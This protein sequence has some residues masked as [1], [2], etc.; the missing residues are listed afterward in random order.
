[1]TPE[2]VTRLTCVIACPFN[3]RLMK[4][5]LES[6]NLQMIC[7]PSGSNMMI[8]VTDTELGGISP[9]RQLLRST[10]I[11]LLMMVGLPCCTWS[12]ISKKH[13]GDGSSWLASWLRQNQISEHERTSLDM[14]CLIT[15]LHLSGTY[16]HLISRVWLQWKLLP[17]GLLILL[18][19][20]LVREAHHV[21]PGF[22][23]TK[24]ARVP[25][26][27]PIRICELLLKENPRGAQP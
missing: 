4:S 12:S 1:M 18:K 24:D 22:I 19:P 11:G 14:R 26:T 10:W 9:A 2:V 25:W 8:M 7:G 21:G 20:T 5:T 16:D 23:T 6:G 17:S 15:C 13:G 27:V 3:L